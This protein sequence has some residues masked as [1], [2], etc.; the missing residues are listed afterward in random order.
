MPIIAQ[1]GNLKKT[2]SDLTWELLGENK[3]GWVEVKGGQT[4]NISA[5]AVKTAP[6]TGTVEKKEA[7]K[8]NA[9]T[10]NTLEETKKVEESAETTKEVSEEDKVAKFL[11]ENKLNFSNTA[12]EIGITKSQIK[13]YFD[14]QENKVA[15][16]ANDSLDSLIGLLHD[17]LNGDIEVLKSKF[18]I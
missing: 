17:S 1:K 12:K 3:N 6:P 5:S 15:Y 18:S 10:S 4:S 14:Q 16:K 13:D 2:F 8:A 7:P 11:E 9:T